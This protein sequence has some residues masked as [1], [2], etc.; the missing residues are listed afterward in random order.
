M[1]RKKICTLILSCLTISSANAFEIYQ[2]LRWHHIKEKNGVTQYSEQPITNI[3][4]FESKGLKNM[5]VI[6]PVYILTDG[7]A[8]RSK[9]K[10]IVEDA[11]L[12][13]TKP[14]CFDIEMGNGKNADDD[15]HVIIEALKI[16]RELGGKAPIGVYAVLPQRIVQ[17]I[18]PLNEEQKEEYFQLNK[19]YESLAKYVDFLSPTLYFYS[20]RNKQNWAT[21]AALSMEEAR[22]YAHKY[23]LKIYPF[24]SLSTWDAIDKKSYITPVSE[25]Y[26][27]NALLIL[28][29]QGADG[30]VVW[31]SAA[32]RTAKDKQFAI[33]ET[34]KDSYKAVI[35]FAKK[36]K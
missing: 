23:D 35:D 1:V 28:K 24:I 5:N 10:K 4:F 9:I 13:P 29:S 21:Q 36:Y 16:Y 7:K 15:L 2:Y 3:D 12:E 27:T 33:F 26:M 34:N 22:K 30:V 6:Y 31:E 20:K 25:E 17:T 8:D 18:K 11:K 32:A 19:Q 14:I